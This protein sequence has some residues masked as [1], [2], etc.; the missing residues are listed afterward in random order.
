[1]IGFNRRF[2]PH[3]VK[4]RELLRGRTEPKAFVMTVNAGAIPA[5]HWTQDPE[6]GGGR[7]LGEGIHFVDLLRHLADAPIVD[8]TAIRQQAENGSTP[9]RDD[10]AMIQLRFADGSI[11]SVQYLAN[12][13]KD[14]PK[15]RLEIFCGGGV[16]QIDNFRVMR[17]YGWKG[18]KKLRLS[19]QD[20]GHAAEVQLMM[21]AIRLGQPCPIPWEEIEEVHRVVLGMMRGT[22]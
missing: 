4:A 17:G 15:E 18:F 1:M 22:G 21:E 19:R 3:V 5:N 10:V 7:I 16:L 11:G 9:V 6:A 12:G 20:K 2:A 14:F 8:V 13:S